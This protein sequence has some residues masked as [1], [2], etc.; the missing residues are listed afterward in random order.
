[1]EST[2]SV[3]SNLYDLLEERKVPVVLANP[4]RTRVIASARIKTNKV[5]ARIPAHLLRADLV[6]ECYIPPRELREIRALVRH[7][8]SIVRARATVKNRVHAIIDRYGLWCGCSDPFGRRGTEWLRGLELGDLDRLMLDNHLS[9]IES[10][11][12][13]IRRV[14]EEIRRRASLDEDVRLLLSMTGV[15]VYT[16]LLIKSEI[17]DIS[18]FPDYKRRVSWAGLAPSIRQSGRVEIR[19]GI[20]KQGSRMLRWIMVEAT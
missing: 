20:T 18:R 15:G 8:A 10:L 2:G 7:R 17:G 14:D 4:L 3:W 5:D 12:Q 9:H 11:N 6:A 19:G 16:A 13:Q 1:M